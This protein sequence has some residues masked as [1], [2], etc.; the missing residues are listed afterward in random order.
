M[1]SRRCLALCR[2]VRVCDE[3]L[4]SMICENV[5]KSNDLVCLCSNILMI[6][7]IV[8]CNHTLDSKQQLQRNKQD[9]I[10]DACEDGSFR[11]F[12]SQLMNRSLKP[13]CP[14][15][16]PETCHRPWWS[17]WPCLEHCHLGLEMESSKFFGEAGEID[18]L[19][20]KA[21][22]WGW[23]HVTFLFRFA[24]WFHQIH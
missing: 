21:Q 7:E 9:E 23:W 13:N 2:R 6:I 14:T 5:R 16:M 15:L 17:W 10:G 1:W 20:F 8:R 22:S 4:L 18:I 3:W 11:M 19:I 12:P 24:A